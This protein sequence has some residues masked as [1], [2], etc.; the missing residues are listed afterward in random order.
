MS[1]SNKTGIIII[2]SS[3]C[4]V[5]MQGGDREGAGL[6]VNEGQNGRS[7]Y[8]GSETS[9]IVKDE[10]GLMALSR[11]RFRVQARNMMGYS[12]WSLWSTVV[13]PSSSSLS[14]NTLDC[15]CC[16]LR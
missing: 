4:L 7:V 13:R 1:N 10:L 11:V 15:C 9:C 12:E 6:W 3:P 8:S 5:A 14:F 2:A 16:Y